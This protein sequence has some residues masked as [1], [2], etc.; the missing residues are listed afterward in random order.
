[1]VNYREM[2]LYLFNSVTDALEE[3]EKTAPRRGGGETERGSAILRG[4]LYPQLRRGRAKRLL[5]FIKPCRD[6]WTFFR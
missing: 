3:L 6:L 4:N 1:M 2:Y 5:S